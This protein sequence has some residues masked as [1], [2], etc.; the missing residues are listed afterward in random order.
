[1]DK[2]VIM[3]RG[4]GTRM[5]KADESTRLSEAEAR[6]A[7]TGVKALMPIEGGRPFL[8]YVLSVLAQAGYRRVCLIIGPEHDT[9][10]EYYGSLPYQ[11]LSIEFA[12]QD[13]PKGTADA[14]AAAE[15]FAAGEPFIVLNSDNYYP[16]EAL[17]G[18]RQLDGPGLAVFERQSMID[19]SNIA[20][21]RLTAFA[22]AEVDGNGHMR[23]IHEKPSAQVI[24]S[25]PEPVG[26]SMNCWRFDAHIFDA[27][28]AI[29]PSPRGE[30]EVTD[31][32]QYTID[33][34]GQPF[35]VLNFAA[36]VLDLS[37]RG[38]LGP[39]KAHLTDKEI[40]L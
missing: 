30:Y 3:A 18:L 31:A 29:E 21:D 12:V 32:V 2:A 40:I 1:M 33:Q 15:E 26:L 9:V 38:D 10:R 37:N 27:C 25:L 24:D 19:H 23:Q 6:V 8:D 14:V 13:E 20:A 28:R 22:V 5:R 7:E 11:H 35:R 4:L 36:P 39:L 16:L 34:L 17:A